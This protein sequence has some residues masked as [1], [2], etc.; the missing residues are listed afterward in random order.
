VDVREWVGHVVRAVWEMTWQGRG[1]CCVPRK[2]VHVRYRS[3]LGV[4]WDRTR[5][6]TTVRSEQELTQQPLLRAFLMPL[7]NATMHVTCYFIQLTTLS[8]VRCGAACIIMRLV[9]FQLCHAGAK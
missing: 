5:R 7:V 2:G 8:L 6:A 4:A 3:A 1:R 9:A